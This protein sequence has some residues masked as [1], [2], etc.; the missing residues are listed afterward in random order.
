VPYVITFPDGRT[1]EVTLVAILVS[2]V[3][4]D[5]ETIADLYDMELD[6]PMIAKFTTVFRGTRFVF[7]R[8]NGSR[9]VVPEA[10]LRR[11]TQP[12]RSKFG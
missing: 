3:Q 11:P 8:A 10:Y 5:R 7:E 9:C 2:G 1:A 6:D 12:V 4:Y